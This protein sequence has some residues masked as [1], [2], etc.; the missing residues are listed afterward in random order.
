MLDRVQLDPLPNP[1][2]PKPPKRKNNN[3]PGPDLHILALELQ[4]LALTLNDLRSRVERI[5]KQVHVADITQADRALL[6]NLDLF[7]NR[8]RR[9]TRVDP[10]AVPGIAAEAPGAAV[11]GLKPSAG[12]STDRS[13]SSAPPRSP[14]H[15][16]DRS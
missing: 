2:R 7:F 5:E 11:P 16:P 9:T 13:T 10:R 15:S 12:S 14:A 1:K 8:T 4:T 6:S 3:K